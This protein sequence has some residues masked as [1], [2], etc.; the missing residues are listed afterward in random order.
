MHCAD[1]SACG[2]DLQISHLKIAM[3]NYTDCGS[4]GRPTA[5]LQLLILA[6]RAAATLAHAW[7]QRIPLELD[8]E[9]VWA[10]RTSDG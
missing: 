8:G 1:R 4:I 2:S 10:A 9:H 7:W 5:R 6:A 3:G